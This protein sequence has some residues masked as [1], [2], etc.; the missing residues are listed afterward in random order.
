MWS[1]RNQILAVIVAAVLVTVLYYAT[2]SEQEKIE[3]A[4]HSALE[5]HEH[6]EA[7]LHASKLLSIQPDHPIAKKVIKESSRIFAHLQ[8]AREAL[9]EFWTIKDGASMEPERIYKGIQQSREHLGKAKSLDPKF[10]VTAEFEEK[11]DEAQAQ[12]IYIFASYVKEIGDGTVSTAAESY[13]KTSKLFD[14]AASSK[15]LSK[16][17]RV[18]SS[19]AS[20]PDPDPK[21]M[22]DLEKRL[23]EMDAMGGLA[24]D[25]Q[26]K[27]AKSLVKALQTY[28]SSVRE[29][30]DTLL[31]PHGNFNEYVETVNHETDA[32]EKAQNKLVDQLPSSFL[33]KVDYSELLQDISEYKFFEDDSVHQIIN[34]S[35]AL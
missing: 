26:G 11:L 9:S 16:F 23:G 31:T 8:D 19:W 17:L 28:M 21:V 4:M 12:L 5:D 7:L 30:I 24:S 35:E 6:E 10:E 33:A 34:E 32:F 2:R 22:Q 3:S 1:K 14:N 13:V 20:K 29:T 15:Y 25:Y 27:A 18:Q